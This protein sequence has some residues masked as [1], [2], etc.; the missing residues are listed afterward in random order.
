MI[1]GRRE[2]NTST[3]LTKEPSRKGR[4]GSTIRQPI[5]V[6]V[7][8]K[9]ISTSTAHRVFSKSPPNGQ[10]MINRTVL[11][12]Y[13][14]LSPLC[15]TRPSSF[16]ATPWAR[17]R[18]NLRDRAR[19]SQASKSAHQ[20]SAPQQQRRAPT[21]RSH[22]SSPSNRHRQP[23]HSRHRCSRRWARTSTHA[24]RGSRARTR[25]ARF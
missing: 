12:Q 17:L 14:L 9:Y 16:L 3:E 7:R 5:G 22:P 11:K 10:D 8:R 25:T 20:S 21:D 15:Q 1:N 24:S 4:Y 6:R 23:A 2:K 13:H 18:S 19:I